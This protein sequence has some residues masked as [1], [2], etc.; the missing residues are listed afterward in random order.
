MTVRGCERTQR[1]GSEPGSLLT[2]SGMRSLCAW[3]QR[4][5]P[6]A[7]HGAVQLSGVLTGSVRVSKYLRDQVWAT[8]PSGQGTHGR[9][10]HDAVRM[11]AIAARKER[12]LRLRDRC[13]AARIFSWGGSFQR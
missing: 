2:A 11:A 12:L 9:E 4:Y 5:G 13:A 10:H 7:R 8:W 6:L 3:L 1:P